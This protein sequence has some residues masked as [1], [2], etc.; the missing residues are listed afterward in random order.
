MP[1]NAGQK[2]RTT[3]LN[4]L[5]RPYVVFVNANPQTVATSTDTAMNLS[6]VAENN[7]GSSTWW[8]SGS[9]SNITV[10]AGL[11]GLWIL[12]ARVY[13]SASAAGNQ[14]LSHFQHGAGA[15]NTALWIT[16]NGKLPS[17]AG[18]IGRAHV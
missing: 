7:T 10:P 6:S 12:S 18:K 17:A 2:L 5:A 14:R 11:G 8:T 15:A 4:T 3:D 9:P 1:V 13:W 16:S